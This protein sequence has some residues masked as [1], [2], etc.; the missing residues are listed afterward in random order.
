MAHNTTIRTRRFRGEGGGGRFWLALGLVC[1]AGLAAWL[2]FAR[3]VDWPARARAARTRGR[4]AEAAGDYPR[5]R[6]F[7]ETALANNPYD[8]ATRLRLA[9]LLNHR[10]GDRAAA[11]R[12][13]LRAL[14]YSPDPAVVPE[15]EAELRI[16]SLLRAGELETP[17]DAV[18]D[19]LAAAESGAEALF[20]GRL[21]GRLREAAPAH[22]RAWRERGRGEI[23]YNR[24]VA[25]GDGLYDAMLELAFPDGATMSMHFRCPLR[26]IWQLNLSFP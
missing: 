23:V 19:M 24:V 7:Y 12:Q 6:I 17:E 11:H 8:A 25:A 21:A 5:A 4:E 13:Y 22:F 3:D 9:H 1:A 18:A 14:A 15:A 26:N 10:L 16:L 20:A 2:V